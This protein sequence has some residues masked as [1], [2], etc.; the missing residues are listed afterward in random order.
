LCKGIAMLNDVNPLKTITCLTMPDVPKASSAHGLADE[1]SSIQQV[2]WG[3]R[4]YCDARWII[5]FDPAP[6]SAPFTGMRRWSQGRF[7]VNFESKE[8]NVW[9]NSSEFSIVGRPLRAAP[10]LP[11]QRNLLIPESPESVRVA[12]RL[13]PSAR[14]VCAQKGVELQ[15]TMLDSLLT[16]VPLSGSDV[17][18]IVNMTGYVEDMGK[19]VIDR[20]MGTA[21]PPATPLAASSWSPKQLFYQSVHFEDAM[22]VY[23]QSRLNADLCD[24]WLDQ[25]FQHGGVKC[26][27]SAPPLSPDE[28]RDIPGAEVAMGNI[29]RLNLEVC[30]RVGAAV[31]LNPDEVRYWTATNDNFAQEF[32]ALAANHNEHFKDRLI[33]IVSTTSNTKG[34]ATT[35]QDGCHP[36][37]WCVRVCVCVCVC[38]WVSVC[39][40]V[41]VCVY[42]RVRACADGRVSESE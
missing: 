23:A 15:G 24:L 26:E 38:V 13:R 37:T 27:R 9:L 40:C 22:H 33:N 2:L 39:V 6:N 5:T 35:L 1:E 28:V 41:C 34:L 8:E 11:A 42:A 19:A 16:G 36:P 7:V 14:Q 25:R 31:A 17:V 32:Q 20:V 3:L 10:I 21:R 30:V 4:Q 29:D 12:D 18:L